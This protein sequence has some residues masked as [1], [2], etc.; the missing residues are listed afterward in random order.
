MLCVSA[1][2]AVVRHRLVLLTIRG[3]Q[4]RFV[5]RVRRGEQATES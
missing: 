5:F 3:M 1:N 2:D 4:A